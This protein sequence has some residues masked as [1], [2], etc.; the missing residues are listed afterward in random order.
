[1]SEWHTVNPFKQTVQQDSGFSA[2]LSSQFAEQEVMGF[3]LLG[4]AKSKFFSVT[5]P[6][7]I[8]DTYPLNEFPE[9]DTS[10][11]CGRPNHWFV[12]YME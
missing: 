8:T 2:E 4:D 9:V 11:S 1:M 7:G 12:K 10:Q 6:C 5:C 3:L